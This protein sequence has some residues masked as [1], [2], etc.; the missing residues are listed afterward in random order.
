M[1]SRSLLSK[2]SCASAIALSAVL[3]LSPVAH[4]MKLKQQNLQ[5]MAVQSKNIISGK[6]IK[7]TDGFDNKRPYTEK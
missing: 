4:A 1:R 5:E 6:V 2:L 3:T 7:V